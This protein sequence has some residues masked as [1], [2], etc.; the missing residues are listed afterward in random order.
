[1]FVAAFAIEGINAYFCMCN[2]CVC[3]RVCKGGVGCGPCH[4]T[5]TKCWICPV[6]PLKTQ[7]HNLY[8]ETRAIDPLNYCL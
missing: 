7:I 6:Q 2:V 4:V 5:N 1:M 8:V 3:A